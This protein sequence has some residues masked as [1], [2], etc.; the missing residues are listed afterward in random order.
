MHKGIKGENPYAMFFAGDANGHTQAWYPEGDTNA[1]GMKLEEMFSNLS[2]HQIINEPTH[3][4]RDDCLPSCIDIILSDQP[5]L[6]MNSGVRPS[7]DP[8][9]KHQITFC[10]LNFKIPP[11]PK[12][13]RKVWHYNRA[14]TQHII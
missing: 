6:I 4:F 14:Q 12:Y 11:P 2:L 7:L 8:A 1:V 9:V 13:R 10:K 5:N 3:F